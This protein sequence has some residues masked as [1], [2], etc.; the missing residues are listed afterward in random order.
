MHKV[1]LL[2]LT[3]DDGIRLKNQL[4]AAGLKIGQDFTWAYTQAK[5]NNDGYE[6]VTPRSVC[7]EFVDQKLATF[8]KIK[9]SV[10]HQD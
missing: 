1:A 4:I 2:H 6:A 10:H 5:Y 9:W 7:F 3:P 8:Y